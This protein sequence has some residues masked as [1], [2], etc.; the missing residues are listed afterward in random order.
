MQCTSA[1]GEQIWSLRV[2]KCRAWS[3]KM[4]CSKTVSSISLRVLTLSAKRSYFATAGSTNVQTNRLH[5]TPAV[6]DPLK[7]VVVMDQLL[8]PHS[9]FAISREVYLLN[10]CIRTVMLVDFVTCRRRFTLRLMMLWPRKRWNTPGV[11][12]SSYQARLSSRAR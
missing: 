3:A 8:L 1:A 10:L 9:H 11:S 12:V 6:S 2:Y 5:Q 4:T 7:F